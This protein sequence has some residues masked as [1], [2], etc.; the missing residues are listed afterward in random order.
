MIQRR[1]VARAESP[2]AV[3][4]VDH[5]IEVIHVE[6]I[7]YVGIVFTNEV[8]SHMFSNNSAILALD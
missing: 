6:G 1:I 8:T 3:H 7:D 4:V 5:D 2:A